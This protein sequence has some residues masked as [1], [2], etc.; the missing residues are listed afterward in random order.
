MPAM[1]RPIL[2]RYRRAYSYL[3]AIPYIFTVSVLPQSVFPL[4]LF[5]SR[6]PLRFR[7]SLFL[8]AR[9]FKKIREVRHVSLLTDL[10]YCLFTRLYL[11]IAKMCNYKFYYRFFE[12]IKIV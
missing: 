8:S 7:I 11:L 6:L 4:L 5:R 3:R 2:P 12:Q 1:Q 9:T 10:L